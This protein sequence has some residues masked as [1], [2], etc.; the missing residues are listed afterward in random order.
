M[1]LLDRIL[2]S[3]TSTSS[4]F[5]HTSPASRPA[6]PVESPAAVPLALALGA[7]SPIDGL[8]ESLQSAGIDPQTV[9]FLRRRRRP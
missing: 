8:R 4:T 6:A 9:P 2:P 5:V 3:R 1:S 7:G